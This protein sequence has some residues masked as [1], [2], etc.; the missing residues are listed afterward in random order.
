MSILHISPDL[1]DAVPALKINNNSWRAYR[2]TGSVIIFVHGVLSNALTCWYNKKAKTF[3]PDLVV[4][5][6]TFAESSVFLGGYYT[7][8]DST[9]FGLADCAQELLSA[10]FAAED[11]PAVLD[12]PRLVFVCHSLGGIVTRYMIERWQRYF[13]NKK[14]GLLLM[15]SPSLG[16]S[17][18]NFLGNPVAL[19]QHEVGRQLAWKS[20]I[21]N[22]LDV[23]FSDL[24]GRHVI[25]E[26]SGMEACEHRFVVY[27]R[28]LGLLNNLMPRIVSADS[29]GRYFLPARRMPNTNH[30]SIV[31]PDS[32][33]H[34][35][36]ALLRE[37]YEQRVE[38]ELPLSV[39]IPPANF[40]RSSDPRGAQ[41]ARET[42]FQCSRL[43]LD[44]D[45]N[46]DG[47]A[48]NEMAFFTITSARS[49]TENVYALRPS[50]V[51][52]GHTSPYLP[53]PN[54]TS[55]KVILREDE[56]KP[57]LVRQTAL[58]G[59]PPTAEQPEEM[60][61]RSIDFN[62]YSMNVEEYR[63]TE[64]ENS[65]DEDY[66][67]KSIR[68]EKL[69]ELIMML[70]FPQVMRLRPNDPVTVQAFQLI[71]SDSEIEDVEVYDEHITMEVKRHF[72]YSPLLQAAFLHLPEPAP[73]TAYRISWRLSASGA[74]ES[75]AAQ[76]AIV[77]QSRRALLSTRPLFDGTAQPTP[78]EATRKEGLL[79]ALAQFGAQ[80]IAEVNQ[81]LVKV[82]V[83]ADARIDP[84]Q[85]DLSLMAIE[86]VAGPP[87][88]EVL[89][90]VA[91]LNVPA[92]YWR[93]ELAV[94]DGIAGRAAKRL[95]PRKFCR[96]VEDSLQNYAYI[97]FDNEDTS[98][99][100]LWLLSIPLCEDCCGP[101]P[102][103]VVNVGA[104]DRLNA[105]LLDALDNKSIDALTRY[106]N[107]QFLKSVLDAVG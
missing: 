39:W 73:W 35:S 69:D 97:A 64:R 79:K 28:W 66:L 75:P 76:M 26:F 48:S 30:S 78:A 104:F 95:Q 44:V 56:S 60:V 53:D 100:H 38:K 13:R 46:E 16:S 103:G 2:G 102:Y 22:D 43:S 37:F 8:F 23:R 50:W 52:S 4:N 62:V 12:H 107:V 54:R 99:Q 27:Y 81:C 93:L 106:A 82:K 49:K 19:L 84:Q 40:R 14:I 42:V 68:W 17:Y 18:A 96:S 86:N 45:I 63:R 5:D 90:V 6:N 29:A 59:I 11:H 85:L 94:G 36:H 21:L 65:D 61:L 10:L 7:A 15:A 87:P 105:K 98:R 25:R 1:A 89:R 58:F 57:R 77:E 51:Q 55:A 88:H 70:R 34:V 33:R 74:P 67:Q 9:D 91:G 24:V 41:L 92:A 20:D 71:R 31:K 83:G 32:D 101:Y 72:Y 80:V 47:D 3:W